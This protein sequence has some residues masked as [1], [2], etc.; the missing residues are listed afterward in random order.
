MSMIDGT[1]SS[2]PMITCMILIE[3][4]IM[5]DCSFGFP[6]LAITSCHSEYAIVLYLWETPDSSMSMTNVHVGFLRIEASALVNA[7]LRISEALGHW[8]TCTRVSWKC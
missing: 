1:M 4:Y 7:P 8:N 3:Y 6:V 5:V 2:L